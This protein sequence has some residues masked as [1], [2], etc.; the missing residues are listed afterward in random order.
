MQ[1][2]NTLKY[3][4]SLL[5]LLASVSAFAQLDDESEGEG[6]PKVDT[7]GRHQLCIGVDIAQPISNS[8]AD[9]KRSYEASVDYFLGKELYG[10]L[11]GG[12][13]NATVDYADLKYKT[14]N[15]FFRAGINKSILVRLSSSDWDMGFIGFRYGFAP[16]SRNVA[17]YTVIDKFFG[18]T[19][20]TIPAK[21]FTGH[22]AEIAGGMRLD[23]FKGICAGWTIRGKFLLNAKAFNEL[24]PSYVAGY[25]KGDKG[26]VFD[27]NFYISYAI[28][29]SKKKAEAAKP[30]A[31]DTLAPAQSPAKEPTR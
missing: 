28:R 6:K 24:A 10:V 1:A 20:G 7:K 19:T 4:T 15:T 12:Y 29:W 31:A 16:I 18:N 5:L 17:T 14:N 22:W 27:Y 9:N 25:G 2:R 13:G 26:S 8:L 23:I 30:A 11:E 3:I 21:N